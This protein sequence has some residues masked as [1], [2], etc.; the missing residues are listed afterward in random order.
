MGP[1]IGK[2]GGVVK[3]IL[4]NTENTHF[5]IK[6]GYLGFHCCLSGKDMRCNFKSIQQSDFMM[7]SIMPFQEEK[8]PITIV[9][10][11]VKISTD[12]FS[13]QKN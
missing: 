9:A 3:F 5:V 6:H 8:G 4:Q 1:E 13:P 11:G 10:K 2:P 12:Q 7:D